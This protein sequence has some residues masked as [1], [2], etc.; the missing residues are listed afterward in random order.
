MQTQFCEGSKLVHEPC[1]QMLPKCSTSFNP[2]K[3]SFRENVT[4][5]C[6]D[7]SFERP[8]QFLVWWS[9]LQLWK[10]LHFETLF[11]WAPMVQV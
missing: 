3:Y 6:D 5:T 2:F 7:F 1:T 8:T 10:K 11:V 4:F 9:A